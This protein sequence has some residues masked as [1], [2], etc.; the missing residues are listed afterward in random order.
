M[1]L[2]DALNVQSKTTLNVSTIKSYYD[3]LDDEDEE[4]RLH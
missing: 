4:I 1:K 2:F 3:G